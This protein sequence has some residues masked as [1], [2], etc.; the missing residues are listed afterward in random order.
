MTR[1][2]VVIVAFPYAE[3]RRGKNRPALVVQNEDDNRRLSNTVVAMISGNIRYAAESTQVLVDPSTT[4]GASSGLHGRSV[5][6]CCNLFTVRQQDILKA[7]GRLSDELL[8]N[9]DEALLS[10]LG[11]SRR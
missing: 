7:I 6:K 1:G 9:V 3:G 5:V 2:D 8:T 10:A 11:L 4:A